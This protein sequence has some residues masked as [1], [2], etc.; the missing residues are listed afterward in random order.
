MV[1]TFARVARG[2]VAAATL[3]VLFA[4]TLHAQA[5][6]RGRSD[7]P[8][9]LAFGFALE[10]VQCE[11][12][13]R[14]GGRG[15]GPLAVWHYRDYPRVVAVN[16]GGPAERAGVRQGDV[17]MSVDGLSVLSDEGARRFS[18]V[19][20]K[21]EV[22]LTFD[23]GGRTVETVLQLG[24][25][26]PGTSPRVPRGESPRD[27]PRYTARIGATAVDV[28]SDLPVEVSSDSDG[29]TMLRIGGTVIRLRS[30]HMAKAEMKAGK[31]LNKP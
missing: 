29:N 20:P 23:R 5:R 18:N 30:D 31:V 28:W 12:S 10:C 17:L 25:S 13:S 2:M 7:G 27:D 6:G 3:S 15:R 21:D 22:R 9:P 24:P 8:R 14:G 11:S 26:F 4:S 16:P 1:L 19:A